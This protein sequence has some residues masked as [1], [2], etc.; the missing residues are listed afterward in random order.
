MIPNLIVPVLNRYDLLRRMLAS[1][2]Y[3][4]RDLLIVD[5]G[6]KFED[7]F[8][9][10]ELPVKNLRV[11]NLPSNLGVAAS[12]NLGIKLFPHDPV[13][14]FASNDVVFEPGALSMLSTASNGSLTLS[15]RPPYWQTFAVGEDLV[16]RV[17]L[18]DERFYPA[19][20]EDNDFERRV[21]L[22]GFPV[23]KLSLKVR[24]DNSSTLKADPKL[25]EANSR[26]F[27]RNKKLYMRKELVGD[28]GWS[29]TLADRRAGEWLR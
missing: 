26:T 29:W 1:L 22:A 3:P 9:K 20:F 4:I 2:D 17:G 6:G 28:N 24:H 19:Y 11:F 27:V 23:T 16:D 12:W 5:N 10:D 13:W 14:T 7:L 18:F 21:K 25:Q 15:D 8:A